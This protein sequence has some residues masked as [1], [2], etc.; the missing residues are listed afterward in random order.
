[1]HTTSSEPQPLIDAPL[2]QLTSISVQV[3]V[4]K[5]EVALWNELVDRH[6]LPGLQK[7]N[8]TTHT[9]FRYRSTRAKTGLPTVL[10][11]QQVIVLA[12]S[13]DWLARTLRVAHTK[14]GAFLL[15]CC[16]IGALGLVWR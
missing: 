10:L 12:Q 2:D 4:D 16:G 8:R 11:W 15:D 5:H 1:M 7:A 6:H 3:A 13:M 14:L 9:L